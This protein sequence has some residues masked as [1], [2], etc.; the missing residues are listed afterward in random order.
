MA[1]FFDKKEL[2]KRQEREF[3]AIKDAHGTITPRYTSPK[4]VFSAEKA[5]SKKIISPKK[6]D[7]NESDYQSG[8]ARTPNRKF[9]SS[10]E[11]KPQGKRGS[12]KESRKL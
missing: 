10:G 12:K 3:Y 7:K 8:L 2:L 11:K 5:K 1:K 4:K 6:I 9:I